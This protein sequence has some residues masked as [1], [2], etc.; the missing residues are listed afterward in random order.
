[1]PPDKRGLVGRE[2]PAAACSPGYFKVKPGTGITGDRSEAY[3][4]YCRAA[5]N[6]DDFHTRDQ[7][8]Y[9]VDVLA[10]E[11][12]KGAVRMLRETF[13]T[14]ARGKLTLGPG[15]F[16]IGISV[17]SA[18][19]N[20]VTRPIEEE[21]QRKMWN[22]RSLWPDARSLWPGK[23]VPGLWTRPLPATCW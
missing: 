14:D 8:R 6:P 12:A 2:C 10:E 22:V 23:L 15:P 4:P 5:A 7:R 9:A 16:G 3:C 17:S 1:M 20:P 19:S 13:G 11:A 21:L 18:S